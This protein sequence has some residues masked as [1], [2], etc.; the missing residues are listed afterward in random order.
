MTES[1]RLTYVV[2]DGIA[3]I[4][5]NHRDGMNTITRATKDALLN[6]LSVAAHDDAVRVLVIT[7]VGRSF[8]VGRD[9]R[10]V[11]AERNAAGDISPPIEFDVTDSPVALISKIRKP[12]IAAVNGV[13]AGAGAGIAFS[14]DFRVLGRSAYF[15]LAF[16]GIGLSCDNGTSWTLPRLV[17]HAKAIELL[18][19]PRAI[20]AEAALEL[21]LATK[22]VD[23]EELDETVTALA[24]ILA[25]GPTLAYG[26]TKEAV[27][28]AA[29]HTLMD[30]LE[31]EFEGINLTGASHDHRDAVAAF[32][33][34]RQ[35]TFGG[36]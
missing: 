23:D 19:L 18:M 1:A 30:A 28:F 16:S 7:G 6:A 14:A 4:V 15:R 2:E 34:K 5:F 13:A 29:G 26:A 8:C 9:L 36:R 21:G 17:G 20:D 31:H 32:L 33:D 22:V 27:G 10:E 11:Q 25:D 35:P 24:R 12:V 3:R